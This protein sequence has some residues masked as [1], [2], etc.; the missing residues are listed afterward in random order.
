MLLRKIL[1]KIN[2]LHYPQEYLCLNKNEFQPTLHVYLSEN[3]CIIKDIT[4][5]HLFVGYSPLIIAL[6]SYQSENANV[7]FSDQSL[8]LNET[9]AKNKIIAAISLKLIRTQKTADKTIAYYL[10]LHGRHHFINSFRQFILNF[11]NRMTNKR[12]G[13]VYLE[14]NLYK[15]VQIAYAVPRIISLVTVSDGKQYNL[16]PTD[17]HGP[18]GDSFYVDSLRHGGKACEQVISSRKM[19]ITEVDCQ[20]YKTVYALGKNHTRDMQNRQEFPFSELNSEYFGLPVPQS[21]LF[22]RELELIDHFDHGIHR[23]ILFK[24][25]FSRKLA[26]RPSTLAHIHNVYATWRRNKGL[27]GNYLMR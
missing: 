17:L 26:E 3:G 4:N 21:A 14:G 27:L 22:Y 1:H 10:G 16:F 2:G 7:I 25:V 24:I 12:P 15:Q 8:S 19:L 11:E 6:D 20:F 5:E 13:N 9:A 18:I 23:I